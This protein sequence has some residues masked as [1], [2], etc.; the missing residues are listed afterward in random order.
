MLQC[1]IKYL[2]VSFLLGSFLLH[3]QERNFTIEFIEGSI[4]SIEGKSNFNEYTCKLYDLSNNN[5]K[6]ITTT[7]LKN[8]IVFDSLVVQLI[9]DGFS[10]NN[11]IMTKTFKKTMKA[12][13]HPYIF[14]QLNSILL[15]DSVNNKPISSTVLAAYSISIGGVMQNYEMD[16]SIS[17]RDFNT[18]VLSGSK[19]LQMSDFNIDPPTAMLGLI[20]TENELTI[21]FTF[22]LRLE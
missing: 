21:N 1:Y 13:E 6:K 3:A 14:L 7:R 2:L 11:K 16:I 19:K 4:L 20:R 5:K 9:T 17:E 22:L 10:C 8:K 12:T 15:K 18:Y